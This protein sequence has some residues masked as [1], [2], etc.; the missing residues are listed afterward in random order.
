MILNEIRG[1]RE[2][3]HGIV[4]LDQ[5]KVALPRAVKTEFHHSNNFSQARLHALAHG[6]GKTTCCLEPAH[7][8]LGTILC[9]EMCAESEWWYAKRADATAGR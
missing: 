5:I 9:A 8:I 3:F 1:C 7:N 2:E 4:L 6:V